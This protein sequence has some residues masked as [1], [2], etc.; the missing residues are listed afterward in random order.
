MFREHRVIEPP[1]NSPTTDQDTEVRNRNPE[2]LDAISE[3]PETVP[4]IGK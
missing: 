1:K 3:A 4:D 2:C